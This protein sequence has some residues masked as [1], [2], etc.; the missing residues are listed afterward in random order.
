MY[1]SVLWFAAHPLPA[2]PLFSCIQIWKL[3]TA[4]TTAYSSPDTL[5]WLFHASTTSSFVLCWPAKLLLIFQD[6][7][8][9]SI[10]LWSLPS[11]PENFPL[12]PHCNPDEFSFCHAS[13]QLIIFKSLSYHFWALSHAICCSKCLT[14][15]ILFKPHSKFMKCLNNWFTCL[16]FLLECELFMG[17]NFCLDLCW[18]SSI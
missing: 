3:T 11:C 10:L 4:Q 1:L 12:R 6:S 13:L 18:I 17:N 15:I 7:V 9:I 8:Q 2:I 16:S 5:C 14:C